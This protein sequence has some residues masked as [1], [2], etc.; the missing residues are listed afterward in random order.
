METLLLAVIQ[1]AAE[2]AQESALRRGWADPVLIT[3]IIA[4]VAQLVLV[5][6]LI[7]KPADEL[8]ERTLKGDGDEHERDDP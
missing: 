5:A 4:V 8:Q 2:P 7:R 1:A 6:R 3:F